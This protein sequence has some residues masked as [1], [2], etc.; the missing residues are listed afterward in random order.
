[1]QG[2]NVLNGILKNFF[3][4]QNSMHRFC[5]EFCV[6]VCIESILKFV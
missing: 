3:I 6:I 5:M 2:K 4:E 1:M